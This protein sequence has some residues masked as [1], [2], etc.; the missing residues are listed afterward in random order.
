MIVRLLTYCCALQESD[1]EGLR[2]RIRKLQTELSD[3][4]EN[5]ATLNA[6]IS[7]MRTTRKPPASKVIYHL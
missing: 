3:A 5:I 7:K 2:S 6:T 4:E 1:S